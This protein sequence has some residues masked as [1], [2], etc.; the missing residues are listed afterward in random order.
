MFL[1]SF[2]L[3]NI[4]WDALLSGKKE[5]ISEVVEKTE[6]EVVEL[7]KKD[8]AISAPTAPAPLEKTPESAI[9]NPVV[10]QPIKRRRR[11]IFFETC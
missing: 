2:N 5:L 11:D 10:V 8:A 1:V 3:N 6:T 7:Q 9:A 4:N